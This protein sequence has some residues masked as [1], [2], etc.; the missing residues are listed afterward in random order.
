MYN[1][2]LGPGVTRVYIYIYIIIY[3][4]YIYIEPVLGLYIEHTRK[5]ADLNQDSNNVV[6]NSELGPG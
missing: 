3:N 5:P 1:S 6:Y 4:I 2:E